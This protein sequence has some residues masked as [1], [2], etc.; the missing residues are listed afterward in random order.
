VN[1]ITVTDPSWR[2]VKM[3]STTHHPS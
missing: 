2:C 1:V 3:S